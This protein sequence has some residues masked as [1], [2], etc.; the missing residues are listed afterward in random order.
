M[1][2]CATGIRPFLRKE[3]IFW[4]PQVESLWKMLLIFGAPIVSF[5][6]HPFQ[7]KEPY[8]KNELFDF[9]GYH[10]GTF[11]SSGTCL[12]T[13]AGFVPL[14]CMMNSINSGPCLSTKSWISSS[15]AVP[16]PISDCPQTAQYSAAGGMIMWQCE[17]TWGSRADF[18]FSPSVSSRQ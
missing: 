16:V 11:G 15:L 17:Q 18:F 5:I 7:N 12:R 9:Y 14:F 3:R 2:S 4:I 8:H 10:L 13:G 1:V 6:S